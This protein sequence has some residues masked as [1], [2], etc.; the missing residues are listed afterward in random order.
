MYRKP[1]RTGQMLSFRSNHLIVQKTSWMRTVFNKAK[2]LQHNGS[3]KS[4]KNCILKKFHR[5]D[6]PRNSERI[7]VNRKN[8]ERAKSS[9]KIVPPHIKNV[10][11][12]TA[13][14]REPRCFT[15]AHKLKKQ[16][17]GK[18]LFTRLNVRTAANVTSA[19]L[20]ENLLQQCMNTNLSQEDMIL[21]HKYQFTKIRKDV[22][23]LWTRP[24]SRDR[25]NTGY[26]TNYIK[27]QFALS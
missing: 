6:Y 13:R 27:R 22:H 21:F 17:T 18:L 23:S 3:A 15:I 9:K 5:S 20:E 14:L 12:M 16:T 24:A 19:K 10:S 11:E 1:T 2:T 4:G 8:K 7:T 26:S 25:G